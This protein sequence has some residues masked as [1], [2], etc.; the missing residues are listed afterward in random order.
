MFWKRSIDSYSLVCTE[1]IEFTFDRTN[2]IFIMSGE[3]LLMIPSY[4]C[5]IRY[6]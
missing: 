2:Q 3:S 1:R 5:Q 4:I 6:D